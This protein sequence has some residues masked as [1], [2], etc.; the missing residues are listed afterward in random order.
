MYSGI[1]EHNSI[2]LLNWFLPPVGTR[3]RIGLQHPLAVRKRRQMGQLVSRELQLV[4][5]EEEILVH[6]D[7]G[8]V[9]AFH[10]PTL[11]FGSYFT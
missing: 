2:T 10:S 8:R 11:H 4:S 1:I 5:V 3:V 7:G 9:V 6:E